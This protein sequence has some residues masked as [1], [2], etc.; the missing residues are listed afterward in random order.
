MGCGDHIICNGLVRVLV[1]R[2]GGIIIPCYPHNLQA[3]T[4]MFRD[5]PR[6]QVLEVQSSTHACA[7]ALAHENFLPLGDYTGQKWDRRRF[8][9]E[10]YSQANVEFKHR[11]D[12]FKLNVD[13]FTDRLLI[14][15]GFVHMDKKRGF[16]IPG[17]R[18]PYNLYRILIIDHSRPFFDWVVDIQTSEEIHVINSSF[19][20]LIDSLPDIE[21]QKLF[22]HEYA[23]PGGERP[24]LKRDWKI[25]S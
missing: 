23:R 2:H 11:W 22:L 6:I 10:F 12:S 7:R 18:W 20:C 24:T 25:I 16:V 14:G 17:N 1:E 9:E 19:L 5:D 8:D 13:Y 4:F 3:V 15:F 21:G